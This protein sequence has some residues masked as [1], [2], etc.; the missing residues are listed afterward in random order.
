M[1]SR[2]WHGWTKRED[3]DT[4]ERMLRTT[5]GVA[6]ALVLGRL[7]EPLLFETSPRDPSMFLAVAATLLTFAV[8]ASVAPT[9]RA[10]RVDPVTAL[11][12]EV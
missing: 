11:R 5:I 3:A 6:L 10:V 12:S 2:V 8:L 1:I 7:V 4:Y 9:R